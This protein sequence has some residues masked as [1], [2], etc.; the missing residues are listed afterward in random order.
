MARRVGRFR[1][2]AWV[3]LMGTVSLW[4]GHHL[5]LEPGNASA[6]AVLSGAFT[7]AIGSLDT[8][9]GKGASQSLLWQ[10]HASAKHLFSAPVLIALHVLALAVAL[11]V[12]SVTVMSASAVA[13]PL[14]VSISPPD[15]GSSSDNKLLG[16]TEDGNPVRFRVFTSPRGRQYI[17][18][19]D[20]FV[21]HR[22]TVY[23]I[24]G[25]RLTLGKEV[26]HARFALLRVPSIVYGLL[27]GGTIRVQQ[28]ASGQVVAAYRIPDTD[29]PRAFV[30]GANASIPGTLS[31]SWVRE[32]ADEGIQDEQQ[33][34]RILIEWGRPHC[35]DAESQLNSGDQLR[36]ELMNRVNQLVAQVSFT[37]SEEGFVDRRLEYVPPQRASR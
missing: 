11:T 23:P 33:K 1:L 16:S 37:V 31:E 29:I 20:G 2:V 36:A 19:A 22:C 24:I 25:C 21:P 5:G 7:A 10:L 6:L 27:P 13:T 35:I 8:L 3:V 34:A 4:C 17:V 14:K 15:S 18:K 30:L 9:L 26:P 12:S 28:I 32:L